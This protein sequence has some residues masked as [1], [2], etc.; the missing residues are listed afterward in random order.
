MLDRHDAVLEPLCYSRATVTST[1]MN[2]GFIN[3]TRNKLE[4]TGSTVK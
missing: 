4:R 3:V 2:L 1:N